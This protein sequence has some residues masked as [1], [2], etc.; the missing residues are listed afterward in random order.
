M[1]ENNQKIVKYD[2]IKKI[3]ADYHPEIVVFLK[4]KGYKFQIWEGKDISPYQTEEEINEIPS[5]ISI[6]LVLFH[7]LTKIAEFIGDDIHGF[8]EML[9]S[10]IIEE[11]EVD[12]Y[13]DL[14]F[15]L[16]E[17]ELLEKILKTG[18]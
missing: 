8:V 6:N 3:F 16:T 7:K 11:F 10:K 17:K 5:L 4:E 12:P 13:H 1:S 9:L 15:W 2:I 14:A 18:D